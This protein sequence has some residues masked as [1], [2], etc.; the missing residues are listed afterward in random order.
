MG[1]AVCDYLAMIKK[2][3]LMALA[4]LVSLVMLVAGDFLGSGVASA[5]TTAPDSGIVV[6]HSD[7]RPNHFEMP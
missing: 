1:K 4:V 5:S 6:T 7:L 3:R 2:I